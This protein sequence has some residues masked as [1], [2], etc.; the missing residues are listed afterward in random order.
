MSDIIITPDVQRALIKG[1][2]GKDGLPMPFVREIFLLECHVAGTAFRNL[3]DIEPNLVPGNI[4]T[5][6]REPGNKHDKLAIEIFDQEEHSLGYVPRQKNEVLARLMDAGKLVFG[7]IESIKNI[8][9]WLKIDVMIFMR[10][11]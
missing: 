2:F 6:K 9:K 1:S 10:D 4:L 7:K 5:F 11:F 3:A 8:N